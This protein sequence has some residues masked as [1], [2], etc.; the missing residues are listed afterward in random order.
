MS[1]NPISTHGSTPQFKYLYFILGLMWPENFLANIMHLIMPY[2]IK[3]CWFYFCPCSLTKLDLSPSYLLTLSFLLIVNWYSRMWP[4]FVFR[5]Y[6][7]SIANLNVPPICLGSL[8]CIHT[9]YSISKICHTTFPQ[10]LLSPWSICHKSGYI[11]EKWSC[12]NLTLASRNGD[13]FKDREFP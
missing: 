4:D 12:L 3:L 1:L 9:V 7:T 8:F 11:N 13:R 5:T 2:Y 6:S 10:M